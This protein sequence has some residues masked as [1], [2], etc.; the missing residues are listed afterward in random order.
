MSDYSLIGLIVGGVLTAAY[1]ISAVMKKG[2]SPELVGAVE[3]ILAALVA[4]SAV[5]LCLLAI[6]AQE[7]V[8]LGNEDRACMVIGSL[9]VMWAW[10]VTTLRIFGDVFRGE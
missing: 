4:A 5:H 10:V 9:G 1:V 8:E 7:L 6:D 2:K 3:L